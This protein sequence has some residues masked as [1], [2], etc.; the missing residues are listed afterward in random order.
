MNP[1]GVYV[2]IWE[3]TSKPETKAEFETLYGPNGEWVQLFRRS[4]GF[5][6]TEF[7]RDFKIENRYLTIDYFVSEAAFGDFLREFSQEYQALDRRCD[8]LCQ[9]EREIGAFTASAASR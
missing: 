9:S 6:G 7:F 1:D 8:N 2:R 3:F 5:L 4:K